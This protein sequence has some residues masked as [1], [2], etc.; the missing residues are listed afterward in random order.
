L[1]FI[2]AQNSWRRAETTCGTGRRSWVYD[3]LMV[4]LGDVDGTQNCECKGPSVSRLSLPRLF[5]HN[6][7]NSANSLSMSPFPSCPHFRLQSQSFLTADPHFCGSLE[8]CPQVTSVLLR[9]HQ[10]MPPTLTT[11]RFMQ[12]NGILSGM[13]KPPAAT[14]AYLMPSSELIIFSCCS[15]ETSPDVVVESVDSSSVAED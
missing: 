5:S 6:Q 14:E 8:K 12:C 10:P 3:H 13:L 4:R 15:V 9:S 7:Q 2:R 11:T 1:R